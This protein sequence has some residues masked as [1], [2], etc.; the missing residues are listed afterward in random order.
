M[1]ESLRIHASDG[2]PLAVTSFIPKKANGHVLLINSATGVKQQFYV[3][4]ATRL[5]EQGFRV[6]TYDYRGIGNS[7]PNTLKKFSASMHEWGTLDYHA[8][9]K[10]IFLTYTDSRTTVIGHSVGGQIIGMSP[11]SENVDRIVTVGA[12][13]P[14]VGN[15]GSGLGKLKLLFFWYAL[16]PVFTSLFGYFPASKLRLFEDLPANVARQWAAWAKTRNFVMEEFPFMK[17]RFNAL[18]QDALMISFSDDEFAPPRAVKNLMSFFTNLQW[19]HWELK[20]QD[21]RLQKLGHFSFFRAN[22]GIQKW[23]SLTR[24]ITKA[25]SLEESKA[26]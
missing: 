21:F 15:F 24:W 22:V 19:S 3:D 8:I 6:F 20:P 14:F 7:K 11:L 16:I 17:Q 1:K 9:L 4:F 5:S 23:E 18:H 12:Q 25:S 2:F 10:Y 26:A 13:T